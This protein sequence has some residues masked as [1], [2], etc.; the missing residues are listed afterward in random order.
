MAFEERRRGSIINP[1][2]L[3]QTADATLTPA[4]LRQLPARKDGQP[5]V[6]ACQGRG[7]P[8]Q[9]TE[10]AE[11]KIPPVDFPSPET[12]HCLP[13]CPFQA[14][15]AAIHPAPPKP[16]RFSWLRRSPG[17]PNSPKSL[18]SQS[19]SPMGTRGK[20]FLSIRIFGAAKVHWCLSHGSPCEH[21]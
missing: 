3:L 7:W 5:S 4:Q 16:L 11:R 17:S 14:N 1:H 21:F 20:H 19:L 12:A 2:F 9:G 6:R 10:G 13:R 18:Y 15:S 8:G